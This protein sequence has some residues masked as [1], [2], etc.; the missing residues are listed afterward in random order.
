[1][2]GPTLF[3]D[4]TI[5]DG[6]AVVVNAAAEVVVNMGL[7]DGGISEPDASEAGFGV[8]DIGGSDIGTV[9]PPPLLISGDATAVNCKFTGTLSVWRC[10]ECDC[11]GVGSD[12]GAGDS[13][14]FFLM[15]NA[16]G[17]PA[18]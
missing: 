2:A 8:T 1:M 7:F 18:G 17:L 11:G 6:V 4:T 5:P 12:R 10:G 3:I 14:R 16:T 13:T 15:S 9:V